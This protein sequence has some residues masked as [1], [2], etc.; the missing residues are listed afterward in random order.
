MKDSKLINKKILISSIALFLVVVIALTLVLVL[1]AC[2]KDQ[3][4]NGG[5][6]N[7]PVGSVTTDTDYHYVEGTLH[8]VNVKETDRAFV[9]R[10]NPPTRRRRQ[11]LS[12]RTFSARRE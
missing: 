7:T 11:T 6:V 3:G 9:T 1:V 2:Q 5:G 12:L 8:K 4:G 10:G